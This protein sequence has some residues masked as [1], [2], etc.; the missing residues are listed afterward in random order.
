[1][2][3]SSRIKKMHFIGVG[4][5]GMSGIA[6]ILVKNGFDKKKLYRQTTTFSKR[7]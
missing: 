1:M 2:I 6:E 5:A 3:P 7:T 4:G